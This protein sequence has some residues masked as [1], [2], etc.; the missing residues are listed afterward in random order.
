[1]SPAHGL[2][3]LGIVAAFLAFSSRAP[4]QE[5]LERERVFCQP[6]AGD[7]K[8][9]GPD[10]PC[11]DDTLE[12]TFDGAT[13]SVL[14]YETFEPGAPVD[15]VIV[16][17]TRTQGVGAWSYA[18]AHDDAFLTLVSVTVDGTE[19]ERAKNG[20]FVVVDARDIEACPPKDPGCE[21]P[22]PG[23]G[24]ISVVI[25]HFIEGATLPL[26]RNRICRAAYV[27]KADP[28]PNGTLVQIVYIAITADGKS[29]EP[30]RLIDGWVKAAG[31]AVLEVC[32][33][34]VDDEGDGKADCDD[35]ECL[36]SPGCWPEPCT[37]AVDDDR[38]GLADCEDPD[39][40]DALPCGPEV[41]DNHWDDDVDGL[42]DCADPECLAAPPCGPEVCNNHQDDD[43]DGFVD[44]DDPSCRGAAP[45]QWRPEVCDNGWDDDRDSATDCEDPECEESPLCPPR[46]E[47]CGGFRDEDRDGLVD[48]DDPDCA[49]AE[50]CLPGPERKRV[51]CD[52][53]DPRNKCPGI[54]CHCVA[55]TLEVTFDGKADSVFQYESFQEGA[56]IETAIVTD[57]RSTPVQGWT[58]GV[59]HDASFLTL[60]DVTVKGTDAEVAK[61]GGFMVA[62]MFN[63]EACLPSDP[64]C[65]NPVPGSGYISAV[66]LSFLVPAE[67]LLQRNS[68]CRATYALAADPGPNGT[69]IQ[70]VDRRLK[71][72]GSPPIEINFIINGRSKAPT[73]I[74][75]GWVKAVGGAQG[76]PAG[77]PQAP[78]IRGD[79]DSS[80][81]INVVD[82]IV[83]I[84]VLFRDARPRYDCDD[85]LDATDDGRIDVLDSL[86]LL[87]FV[88][89][90]GSNLPAPFPWCGRDPTAEERPLACEESIC[91]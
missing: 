74:A 69:L 91:G 43:G 49:A 50:D 42:V 27:L 5:A 7:D 26:Q 88:F 86:Y 32:G 40:P 72:K 66:I 70:I 3:L 57:T 2:G 55:D 37:N 14:E 4:A 75:D 9:P 90:R 58:F 22:V 83:L 67:L 29:R 89:S 51:F 36:N 81:R 68:L 15:T 24:Y 80:G 85:L 39:C 56:P 59:E 30:S 87:R 79:A 64:G 77:G 78:F 34:G 73:R 10:C 48:C 82:P 45:C 17:D 65:R 1:M 31:E 53:S 13:R 52:E 12:V 35:P 60:L 84:Q 8:C 23:A 25:L 46:P 20:G 76:G 62:D 54:D 33:N 11:V 19:A 18:V 6:G 47:V 21:N 16:M 63:I 71:K 61:R 28:G 38:D 41:C 44:C